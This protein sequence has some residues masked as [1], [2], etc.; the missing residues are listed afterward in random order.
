[1]KNKQDETLPITEVITVRARQGMTVA[2]ERRLHVEKLRSDAAELLGNTELDSNLPFS[3]DTL[4]RY[5]R[6]IVERFNIDAKQFAIDLK[7]PFKPVSWARY[8]QI[9]RKSDLAAHLFEEFQLDKNNPLHWRVLFEALCHSYVRPKTKPRKWTSEMLAQL[10]ADLIDV[11]EENNKISNTKAVH[12]LKVRFKERYKDC[13]MVR[14]RHVIADVKRIIG[15]PDKNIR[16][17]LSVAFGKNNL[18][19]SKL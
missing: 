12:K 9:E 15:P 5:E 7:N 2:R 18:R 17:R 16:W 6:E 11:W 8:F 10:G 3:S 14:L 1:M 4:Q 13:Q 19:S